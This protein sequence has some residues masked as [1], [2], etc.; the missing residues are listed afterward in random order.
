[1]DI[2]KLKEEVIG[3]ATK[4]PDKVQHIRIEMKAIPDRCGDGYDHVTDIEI[5]FHDL[6][7]GRII[8]T[9]YNTWG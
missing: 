1:M 2:D 6:R 9:K 3:Y 8:R 4:N 5:K 7:Q